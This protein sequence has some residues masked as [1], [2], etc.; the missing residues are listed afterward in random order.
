MQIGKE[1]LIEKGKR[2]SVE[3]ETWSEEAVWRGKRGG[4]M[5]GVHRGGNMEGGA[6]SGE[7]RRG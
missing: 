3:G 2:E 1:G 6:W 7:A 4:G 5:V